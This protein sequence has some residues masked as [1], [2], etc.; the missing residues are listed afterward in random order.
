MKL[1]TNDS[2]VDFYTR[3]G[4]EQHQL[5]MLDLL[6]VFSEICDSNNIRYWL[7]GGTLLGLY[8]NGGLIPWDDDMDICVPIEDYDFLLGKISE[9]CQ[10]KPGYSLYFKDNG[11]E[12]WCEYFCTNEYLYESKD[13]FYKPVKID[14][15]PV[16]SLSAIELEKDILAVEDVAFYVK[17]KSD[18]NI[19]SNLDISDISLSRAISNK[20]K[21]LKDYNAYM[22]TCIGDKEW[23][24]K[25]HG[26]YSPIK[27]VEQRVVYPLRKVDFLGLEVCVPNSMEDYLIASYGPNYKNLPKVS[28]RVPYNKKTIKNNNVS[29]DSI[30]I[31]PYFDYVSFFVK[32]KN[33]GILL[34]IKL[35]IK[36]RGLSFV[37]N[38][39]L[40]TIKERFYK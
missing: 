18:F 11:L 5:S 8:R 24:V 6:D 28:S 34:K 30:G 23:L 21:L 37:F 10:S 27:K 12:S 35:L 32:N 29:S 17:G 33:L 38:K 4:L 39:A 20:N 7:D 1:V 16:K 3:E 40:N 36:A 31:A 15:L 2:G 9:Y 19:S 25:A 13:G 22:R 14:L 26:Q